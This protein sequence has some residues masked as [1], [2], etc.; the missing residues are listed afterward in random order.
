MADFRRLGYFV[1]IAEL[2]SLTRAAERL[3]VAQPSLSRQMRLLEEELGVALFTRGPR[4]MKLTEAGETLRGRISGPLRLIGHALYEIRSLPG[5]T[6]GAVTFGM[7]PTFMA[8]VGP[9]LAARV[10]D[11]APKISLHLV[12]GYSGHLLEWMKR[13]ELDAALLYGP[14]PSGLN[15]TRILEDELVLVARAG[16]LDEDDVPVER[17]GDLPL[18]LPSQTHGLRLAVESAA[19]KAGVALNVRFQ[20][21]SFQLMMELVRKGAHV[22]V[23][24]PSAVA[25]LVASGELRTTRTKPALKRNVYLAMLSGAES[26]KAVLQVGQILRREVA[27]MV[28]QGFFEAAAAPEAGDL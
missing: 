19:A 6:V 12:E 17:L 3:R 23:L 9:R 7:P 26:P 8:A 27:E 24:P 14:T 15:A 20:A 2:G 25:R 18:V 5:D 16:I 13:A 1:Q 21:D 28:R 22:G 10:A 4:G 11:E